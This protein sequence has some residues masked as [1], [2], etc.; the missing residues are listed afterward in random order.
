MH[1]FDGAHVR[2]H[3]P[4]LSVHIERGLFCMT[5]QDM[6]RTVVLVSIQS[7]D[8]PRRTWLTVLICRMT[9]CLGTRWIRPRA[10]SPFVAMEGASRCSC[11]AVLALFAWPFALLAYR[12]SRA[13]MSAFLSR[14]R[15]PFPPPAHA[16]FP[17]VDVQERIADT[18]AQDRPDRRMPKERI[19]HAHRQTLAGPATVRE[20]SV[21]RCFGGETGAA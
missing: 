1:A 19:T 20:A 17:L 3:V 6:R 9:R 5:T 21:R 14:L 8:G 7:R 2:R 15:L 10:R 11:P 12:R 4:F 13:R 16:L 18:P